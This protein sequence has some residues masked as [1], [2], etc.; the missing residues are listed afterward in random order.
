MNE[1][2]TVSVPTYKNYSFIKWQSNDI[3]I[4]DSTSTT[5][6][7]TLSNKNVGQYMTK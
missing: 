4:T 3:E 1:T 7:A 6:K 5:I 2:A